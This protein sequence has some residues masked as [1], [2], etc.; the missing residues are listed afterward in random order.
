M[1]PICFCVSCFPELGTLQPPKTS[2]CFQKNN[3]TTNT[4]ALLN[5]LPDE[6]LLHIRSLL[7]KMVK[8]EKPYIIPHYAYTDFYSPI[9]Q[10]KRQCQAIMLTTKKGVL[11]FDKKK[12]ICQHE[13]WRCEEC[14]AETMESTLC[15]KCSSSFEKEEEYYFKTPVSVLFK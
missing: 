4:P 12:R 6:L 13:V 9:T 2:G 7:K 1:T 8:K 5:D 15:L 10:W 14:F 3:E 11:T